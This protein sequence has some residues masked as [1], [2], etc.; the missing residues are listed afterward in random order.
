MFLKL[1]SLSINIIHGSNQTKMLGVPVWWKTTEVY[2]A[3]LPY[4]AIDQLSDVTKVTHEVN[5]LLVSAASDA[6]VPGLQ[7]LLRNSQIFNINFMA[8]T[9][10]SAEIEGIEASSTIQESIFLSS[11]PLAAS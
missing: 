9:P 5:L 4:D 3:D 1:N 2:R 11:C 7:K 10:S 6:R 8:R